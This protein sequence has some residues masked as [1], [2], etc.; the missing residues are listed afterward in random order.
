VVRHVGLPAVRDVVRHVILPVVALLLALAA[1]LAAL[2]GDGERERAVSAY[3]VVLAARLNIRSAP[4]LGAP[5][6]AVAERGERLCAIGFD[7]DWVEVRTPLDE[8]G[9]PQR[10]SGFVSRGFVSETRATSQQLEEMG[11]R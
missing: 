4:A 11:C 3:V 10:R 6:V 7:A 5:V 1:P 8:R 2:Q 9:P